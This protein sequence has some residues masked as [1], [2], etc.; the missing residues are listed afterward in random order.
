MIRRVLDCSSGH[1]SPETW[2]WL[3]AQLGDDAV[4][5]PAGAVA[6]A[7]GGGRTRYGWFVYADEAA[8]AVMPEDLRQICVRARRQGAAFI[9]LNCDVLPMEDLP[10]LHPDFVD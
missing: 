3:D 4:R 1:L 8:E 2:D 9:L 10:V 7:L 6:T 5:D